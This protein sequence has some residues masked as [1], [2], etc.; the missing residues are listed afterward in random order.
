MGETD[1]PRKA[2]NMFG[3]LNDVIRRYNDLKIDQQKLNDFKA[4]LRH[5]ERSPKPNAL[6]QDFEATLSELIKQIGER[7]EEFAKGSSVTITSILSAGTARGD[8]IQSTDLQK[9]D[10]VVLGIPPPVIRGR[11]RNETLGQFQIELIAL[12]EE[13]NFALSNKGRDPK[14]RSRAEINTDISRCASEL[15]VLLKT[16]YPFTARQIEE[17]IT[18]AQKRDNG[19]DSNDLNEIVGTITS[20]KRRLAREARVSS[21]LDGTKISNEA[22]LKTEQRKEVPSANGT[23][24]ITQYRDEIIQEIHTTVSLIHRKL[25][26]LLQSNAPL[27]IE[28]AIKAEEGIADVKD[29]IIVVETITPEKRPSPDVTLAAHKAKT[30]SSLIKKGLEGLIQGAMKGAGEHFVDAIG[31]EAL[32]RLIDEAVKLIKKL[33]LPF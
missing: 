23:D 30:F 29:F 20:L 15:V 18:A 33:G 4:K 24:K 27:P 16:S 2:G 12:E 28:D 25:D 13:L 8:G 19:I 26:L 14:V 9:I 11:P 22:D 6:P 3:S 32:T 17:G 7:A 5:F 31:W 1:Y 21:S 10:N